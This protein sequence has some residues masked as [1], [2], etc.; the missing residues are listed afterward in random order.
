MAWRD[1]EQAMEVCACP[2]GS[3]VLHKQL[4]PD[5]TVHDC[6]Q[7]RRLHPQLCRRMTTDFQGM[8]VAF[9]V[10]NPLRAMHACTSLYCWGEACFLQCKAG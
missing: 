1:T 8:P 7:A 4:E 2:P 10:P 9:N 5:L 6:L 3:Q